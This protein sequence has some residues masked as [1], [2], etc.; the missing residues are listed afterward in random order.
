MIAITLTHLRA[1]RRLRRLS[2]ALALAVAAATPVAL[3][4]S[5]Q[6]GP[7]GPT[8]ILLPSTSSYYN[9]QGFNLPS[10]PRPTGQDIVRGS[11]GISCQ[12]AVSGS[13]P[14]LD[15]GVIGTDDP[16]GRDSTSVYG[17]ISVQLGK[18]PGRVDCTRLYD[19]ELERLRLELSLLREAQSDTGFDS[20]PADMALDDF[21][22]SPDS[23][24]P[25]PF[26]LGDLAPSRPPAADPSPGSK[27]IAAPTPA[28]ATVTPPIQRTTQRTAE[29]SCPSGEI[30]PLG[31]DTN[32]TCA[33]HLSGHTVQLSAFRSV[34]RARSAWEAVADTLRLPAGATAIIRPRVTSRGRFQTVQVAGL[35]EREAR[36]LCADLNG[37]CIIRH[38]G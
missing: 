33:A 5:P 6:T 12:S 17:R 8:Q 7:D 18:R 19:L 13:G 23:F 24:A 29:A 11:G 34:A 22:P 32:Q 16:F 27:A 31:A 3:A 15:M 26:K 14:M 36:A 25:P 2:C 35:T 37:E 28:R 9:Q 10:A 21:G 20:F 4:Q 1:V 30:I 38:E